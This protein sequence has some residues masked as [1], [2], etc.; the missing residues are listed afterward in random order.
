[1]A[2]RPPLAKG[3]P[4]ST[5]FDAA[6]WRDLGAKSRHAAQL[7][8]TPTNLQPLRNLVHIP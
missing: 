5:V 3:M 6:Q 8:V 7:A 1:M 2:L 4:F